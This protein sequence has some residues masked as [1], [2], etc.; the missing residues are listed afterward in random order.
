[1]KILLIN[2]AFFDGNAFRNRF[3]DYVDWIRGGNLYVAPFE[4][5]LGLAYLTAT[6][7]SLGHQVILLDMQ[8]LMMDSEALATILAA[9]TPDVVGITAMTPTLPEALRVAD[10][11]KAVLPTARTVLGGVHPTL[12]PESVIAH[13]SV[14]Y[15]IRGEGEEAFPALLDVLSGRGGLLS[16]VPGLCFR[17]EGGT[18][19]AGRA[20]LIVDLDRLPAADY[21]AFP[22]EQY[23]EHNSVLRGIRGISMIVSRGCPYSCSFCAVQQT[24][25]RTWRFQSPT[26]VVDQVIHLRDTYGIEGIWFKDSIFNLRPAWTRE[27]CRQM[28]ER[29]VGV[30][31][32]ALTRIN[33][34]KDDELAMMKAAGLTQ[35]DLGIESGSPKSLKRLNKQITVE[36]IK[37]KV[38]LARRHAKVFGFFM[39][40]IPGEDEDDVRQTFDLARQ[41]ELD[42]W[43]WSIYSPLP[44][45]QLYQEL[46]DEGRIRPFALDHTRVHFTEAYDGICAIPPDR[47]KQL[48]A[49]INDHF[50]HRQN[51][52]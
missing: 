5:P 23:I 29:K 20:P 35:I 39:I 52:A 11:T 47:L 41:I 7:K 30:E 9:E 33:L 50:T 4:P 10:L 43:S 37:D 40:G 27:F 1:M 44:G 19:I 12:D 14:D 17:G 18:V 42:R 2:P 24:M 34:L 25:G 15:V 3:T 48:Y 31:W 46:I 16:E 6:V 51:A 21:A 8:G 36:Q 38:A 49:E 28:I 26:K 32:Q 22:V 13:P 45:S